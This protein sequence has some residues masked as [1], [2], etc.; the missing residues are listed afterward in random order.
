MVDDRQ[1]T[2]STDVCHTVPVDTNIGVP[3][4]IGDGCIDRRATF[5]I[6][7]ARSKGRGTK[8]SVSGHVR[9]ERIILDLAIVLG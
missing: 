3:V 1:Q 6:N 9:I 7:A 5:K 2:M 8:F 4:R